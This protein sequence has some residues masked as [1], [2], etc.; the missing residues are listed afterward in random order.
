VI[1][2]N[3]LEVRRDY[4]YASVP[5]IKRFSQSRAFIRG[6]MGPFGSGKSSGCVIELVKL[7]QRQPLIDGK[8]R[9]RFTCIR[10]TY[11]QLADTTIKTF[12]HWLPNQVFGT[13]RESDHSYRLNNL[14]DLDVEILFRALDRPEHVA[15]LLSLELT[16]A[17]VNEAREVPW[18]V[19]RALKGRVD[20]YPPRNE[21]GCVDPGIFMDSNPADDDSW[22]Y[23]LFEEKKAEDDQPTN[24]EIFKQPSGRSADAENLPNLSPNYYA[25]LM[26]D[27]D[28]D[29]IRVYV[30]GLYGFV[31]D[32]KPVFPEY[33]DGLH[34]A[35]VESVPGVTIK[36]G[37]DFGLTPACIFTQL[38]PD[39][40]WIVFEEL[41]GDDIG[42]STFADCV[43]ELCAQRFAGYKFEDYGDP[44]GKQRSA[45][46]ADRDEKTC[47]DILAG[48]GIRMEAGQQNLT[49]RLESVRKPLNTLRSGKPQF[50]ISP[51]C[52]VL[53]KG[54]LGRYQYR[55]VKVAGSAERYHD[56]PEKNEYSHPHDAL[57]YVATH[58]FGDAVRGHE[59]R[60]KRW[61]TPIDELYRAAAKRR[62]AGVV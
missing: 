48:K 31:K 12:L 22:W 50:Q 1:E 2:A 13:Y 3:A 55:R 57:Q 18:A 9:A 44:A 51:R 17:W 60:R 61:E 46:T 19:I 33:N 32:G 7:A 28:P 62:L 53:R 54:F 21:G 16:A 11:G 52:T 42:I 27:A 23:K 56:E 40:R 10:N 6:L 26:A 34:C 20:R 30:D 15:N 25:N 37:W 49:A 41:C 8:R 39:G 47:Y 29:F 24:A 38:L 45:M 43:L 5:T 35:E 36:R 14:G 59:E 58:V 4:S